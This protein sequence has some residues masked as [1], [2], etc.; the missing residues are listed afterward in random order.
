[1]IFFIIIFLSFQEDEDDVIAELDKLIEADL[2]PTI[3]KDIA[4]DLPAVPD[5]EPERVEDK[6][7]DAPTEV[8]VIIVHIIVI[9]FTFPESQGKQGK[10]T[11]GC[12]GS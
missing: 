10:A 11:E 12:S 8:D 2:E 3:A 4:E 6:L 1:M 5:T 9:S 7:P